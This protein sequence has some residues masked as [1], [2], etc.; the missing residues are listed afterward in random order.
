M[1]R[2]FRFLILL[3][4]FALIVVSSA[5]PQDQVRLTN[6]DVISMLKQGMKDPEIINAI[7][8]FEDAYDLS[9]KALEKL[10]KAGA[11]EGVVR[12]MQNVHDHK[13]A[14]V[15]V[16]VMNSTRPNANT[17][18]KHEEV[19]DEKEIF[20]AG[21]NGITEPVCTYCPSA[22]FTS[23]A[24]KNRIQDPAV[25]LRVVI[26]A[27]GRAQNITVVK[28]PGY[29]MDERAIEAVRKWRFR[30]AQDATGKLVHSRT[31]LDVSFRLL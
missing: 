11:S 28:S 6:N 3:I 9:P 5:T 17:V 23:E 19:I 31:F 13:I 16:H 1:T 24:V 25:T 20:E 30:P 26:T 18:E 15:P 29:G 12:A 2:L 10:K 27:S 14:R 22:T 21:K 8:S 7:I 4:G